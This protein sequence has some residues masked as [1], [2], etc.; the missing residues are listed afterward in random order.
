MSCLETAVSGMSVW[1]VTVSGFLGALGVVPAGDRLAAFVVSVIDRLLGHAVG[2]EERTHRKGK[3]LRG[4]A[5]PLFSE[6]VLWCSETLNLSS[7]C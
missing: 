1:W 6:T 3:Q 4:L 2:A 7:R 5:V